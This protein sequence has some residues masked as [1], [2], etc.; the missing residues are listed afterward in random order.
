[1]TDLTGQIGICLNGTSWVARGIHWATR[2]PCNHVVVAVTPTKC[3]SA[4][5]GGVRHRTNQAYKD[6]VWFREPL[7]LQDKAAIIA[8]ANAKMSLPYN[9]A[10]YPALALERLTGHPVPAFI[11]KWL[12]RRKNVDCSQLADDIYTAAGKHLFPNQYP[13]L[14][15]PGDFYRYAVQH[16]YVRAS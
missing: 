6:I 11:A 14:V 15:T 8:A 9:Y 4:E 12:G 5:P 1:M 7:T 2:S 16:G 13:D 10:I 3:V